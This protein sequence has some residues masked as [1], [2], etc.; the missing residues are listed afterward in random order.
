MTKEQLVES[1]RGLILKS[2]PVA[3]NAKPVHFKRVEAAASHA[4]AELMQSL[5]KA[6]PFLVEG[7]FTK[8]VPSQD[9]ITS[10]GVDYVV[11]PY[12]F[13]SLPNGKGIWYVRPHNGTET[14]INGAYAQSSVLNSLPIGNFINDTTYRVGTIDTTAKRVILFNHVGDSWR[15]SVKSVDVG[16]VRTFDEY[17][18]AEEIHL[19]G[20]S[21]TFLVNNVLNWFG[22]RYNDKI[23]NG[24]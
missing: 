18:D 7:H 9:V 16:V 24:Q 3:D 22:Q 1:L 13:V 6:D 20:E 10:N 11:I 17:D 5:Y 2:E 21:Y 19:P 23:D 15:R 4:F 8:D 14:Y 12:D